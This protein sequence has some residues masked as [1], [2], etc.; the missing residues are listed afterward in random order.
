MAKFRDDVAVGPAGMSRTLQEAKRLARI[1]NEALA[2]G[3]DAARYHAPDALWRGY[4]PWHEHRGAEEPH[5]VFWKPLHEA[6][7]H[8][9]RR[10]DMF[11]AGENVLDEGGIWVV[12]MGHL[13]GLFDKPFL[14][15]NPTGKLAFLRYAQFQRVQ[16]Q[17]ITDTAL[18]VDI[19]H[20]MEQAGLRPFP[21][22]TGAQLVQPGPQTHDGLLYDETD[23]AEG[24]ATMAAINY[25]V[26]DIARWSGGKTE[27][28]EDELRRSWHEDMLWWGPTGIGA[29]YTIPRYA[30]QHAGPFRTAFGTRDFRG[31]VA[32]VAEGTVGG[33]F[34]WP[35]LTLEH[36]G[37]FMGMPAT[38]QKGDLRVIDLY[39]RRGDKLAE[40]W[41]FIDL[42]HFWNMQ[43][44]DIL[45]RTTGIGPV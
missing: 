14:G 40:N 34:G 28:L 30:Q 21:P 43:G 38:G 15:I 23:P 5:Q 35:N 19:P 32:K 17:V 11:F 3:R 20:L 22:Q 26:T 6:L 25:M 4:H 13:M 27:P 42:L 8:L 29:T 2:A 36:K 16:G 37:D 44:V 10:E 7:H 12:S 18:F 31:H 41:I 9:Q 33:F 39:R 45:G 1:A 24:L